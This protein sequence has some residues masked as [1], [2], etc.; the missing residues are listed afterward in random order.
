M[1]RTPP[2]EGPGPEVR[3][4]DQ[5]DRDGQECGTCPKAPK[6]LNSAKQEARQL[7]GVFAELQSRLD[8][9]EG[10]RNAGSNTL[11]PESGR[12]DED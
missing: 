5:R 10:R 3:S 8:R 9:V 12:S 7:S 1:D 4:P 2:G 6:E 11:S